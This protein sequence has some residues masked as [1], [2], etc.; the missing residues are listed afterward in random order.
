MGRHLTDEERASIIRISATQPNLTYREIGSIFNVVPATVFNILMGNKPKFSRPQLA[1]TAKRPIGPNPQ[2]EGSCIR[3]L[4][5]A[6][7]MARNGTVCRSR[8]DAA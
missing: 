4:T 7:L 5:P 2:P 1:T 6:Q 8:R 3:A